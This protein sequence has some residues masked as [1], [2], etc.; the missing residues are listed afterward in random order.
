MHKLILTLALVTTTG[1]AAETQSRAATPRAHG[2][3]PAPLVASAPVAPPGTMDFVYS[4]APERVPTIV[5]PQ[6]S[7]RP[8]ICDKPR[9]LEAAR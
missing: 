9:H 8:G 5:T 4:E 3:T 6:T 1:C 2:L 7:L